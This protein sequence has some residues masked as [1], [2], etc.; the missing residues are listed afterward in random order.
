[1]RT[2][3]THP[4]QIAEIRPAPGYGK[5]GITFCPGKKQTNAITGQWN[6]DLALDLD[7]IQEWNAA[8]V[9]TLIETHELEQLQVPMLG[10]EVRAR[11]M[12]WLHLPIRDR[13]A[14]CRAFDQEWRTVGADL[15]I[16]LMNGFNVLIHCM[17]GLGRAGTVAARL[18]IEF[19]AKPA[20]ATEMVRA[21][22]P[23]A[24]ETEEQCQYLAGI[25]GALGPVPNRDNGPTGDRAM[26]ALL[27]LAV[28]DALGTTLE[29]RKRDSYPRLTDMVGGGPFDLK[30]GEWT[31]DTSMAICLAASLT[32]HSDLD[33]TNLMDRFVDWYKLGSMSCKSYCFDIGEVTRYAL[34]VYRDTRYPLAGE[35][36]DS[37][38]G[39]GSLMRLSP[40]AIRH[41]SDRNKM[42]DIA[43]R[44]SRTTHGAAEAVDACVAFSEVLADAIEGNTRDYV[45]RARDTAYAGKIAPIMAGEWRGKPRKQIRSSGYVVHSLQAALWC[46]GRTSS[47]ED[48]VLLAANLGDD[49]DTTAAITGQLAG[50]L[51]GET[52]IPAHWLAKLSH[53]ELLHDLGKALFDKSIR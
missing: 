5:I 53:L 32:V 8:I 51:Y 27:G 1:M 31:D 23:G 35:T 25:W 19:G 33:E 28:G 34:E 17:G 49:A 18:L 41:W 13:E 47:F 15:R 7:V 4:L 50:A 37:T 9:V 42:R 39:N 44:Q 6:R 22:R 11:H 45:L 48:A 38:A 26:G 29:F 20:P 52:C 46:V 12:S 43:A 40:V 3:I 10:D 14:P 16:L 36:Q 30:A 24:I 21:V 2:S